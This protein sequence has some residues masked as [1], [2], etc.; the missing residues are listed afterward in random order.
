M[1]GHHHYEIS[2]RRMHNQGGCSPIVSLWFPEK[3]VD[4]LSLWNGFIL[5]G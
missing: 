4:V 2:Q 5:V 3:Y 1:G